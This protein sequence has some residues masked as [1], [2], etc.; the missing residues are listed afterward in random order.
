MMHMRTT[1]YQFV[2]RIYDLLL[3]KFT[4]PEENFK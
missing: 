1:L 3:Q 2:E 4:I